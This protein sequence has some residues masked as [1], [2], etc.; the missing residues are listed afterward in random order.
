LAELLRNREAVAHGLTIMA[1]EMLFHDL[2][3][4]LEEVV[5]ERQASVL[6]E[7]L[8][9]KAAERGFAEFAHHLGIEGPLEPLHL[10]TI[11]LEPPGGEKVHP[12]QVARRLETGGG[13]VTLVL[14]EKLSQPEAALLAGVVAGVLTAAG[15]PARALADTSAI[16]HMCRSGGERPEYVVYPVDGEKIVVERLECSGQEP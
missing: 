13:R 14:G 9:S 1:S 8:A 4:V 5:G 3:A 2:P 15:H 6:L 10:L 12:F 16:Q 7:R 11:F